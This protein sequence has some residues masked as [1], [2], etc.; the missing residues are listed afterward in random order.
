MYVCSSNF[1]GNFATC[2][3]RVET[4]FETMIMLKKC[5]RNL[6][7]L[8]APWYSYN[9]VTIP[10]FA[11]SFVLYLAR[12]LTRY[13]KTHIR[14][15]ILGALLQNACCVVKGAYACSVQPC[16][17]QMTTRS[18][19]P[20]LLSPGHILPTQAS[21]IPVQI[22]MT[23]ENCNKHHKLAQPNIKSQ[24]AQGPSGAIYRTVKY[25]NDAKHHIT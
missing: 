10:L 9:M 16:S 14:F 4:N 2:T 1:S 8:M 23:N 18:M 21:T 12:P 3:F 15:C 5:P 11:T 6:S 22:L 17:V 19:A 20:S 25:T 7:S 13:G 24:M